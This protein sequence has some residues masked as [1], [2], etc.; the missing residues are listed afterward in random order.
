MTI[1]E[2]SKARKFCLGD[3]NK[4]LQIS[5]ST[6]GRRNVELGPVSGWPITIEPTLTNVQAAF[7]AC[8]VFPPPAPSPLVFAGPNRARAR[9]TT[10]GHE[11][12][13]VQH[14]V[15]HALF[16]EITPNIRKRPV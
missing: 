16:H 10:D 9:R 11:S 4:S 7:S 12:T 2:G 13:I 3:T 8:R 6:A 1:L 5:T 15:R 14:V